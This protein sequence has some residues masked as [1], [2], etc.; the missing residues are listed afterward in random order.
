MKENM[1][2]ADGG[3]NI[4]VITRTSTRTWQGIAIAFPRPQSFGG[5]SGSI[6]VYVCTH[7]K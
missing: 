6:E 4:T 2:W 3:I 7:H 5:L 1:L